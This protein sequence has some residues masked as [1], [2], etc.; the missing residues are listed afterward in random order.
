MHKRSALPHE[1]SWFPSVLN[2]IFSYPLGMRS[3]RLYCG[4]ASLGPSGMDGLY[5]KD[6]Q[7]WYVRQMRGMS[8]SQ[9]ALG[10]VQDGCRG[11][12]CI[13]FRHHDPTEYVTS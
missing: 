9:E 8:L 11:G 1:K 4:L 6:Y 2:P 5:Y 13:V 10:F 7:R 12:T 3:A